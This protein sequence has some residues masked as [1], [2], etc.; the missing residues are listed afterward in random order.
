MARTFNEMATALE[1]QREA[2]LAFLAGIAHANPLSALQLSVAVAA[3]RPAAV[4]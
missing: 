1:R 3:L 4:A 2:R